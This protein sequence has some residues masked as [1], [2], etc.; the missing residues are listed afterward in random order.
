MNLNIVT[1]NPDQYAFFAK[2][3]DAFPKLDFN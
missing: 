2:L 1:P 3:L